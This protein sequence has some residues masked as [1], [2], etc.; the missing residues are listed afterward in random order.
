MPKIEKRL[1]RKIQF[2]RARDANRN[3]VTIDFGCVFDQF[4]KYQN[5]VEPKLQNYGNDSVML[6]RRVTGNDDDTVRFVLKKIRMDGIPG[7]ANLSGDERSIDVDEDEGVTESTHVV[8]FPD[9]IIGV[10][11]NWYGPHP[12]TIVPYLTHDAWDSEIRDCLKGA[13]TLGVL[14]QEG[15][16]GRVVARDLIKSITVVV[17]SSDIP[18]FDARNSDLGEVLRALRDIGKPHIVEFALKAER[19]GYLKDAAARLR[20]WFGKG[21]DLPFRKAIVVA[22]LPNDEGTHTVDL[23]KDRVTVEKSVKPKSGRSKEISQTD[24]FR[25]IDEG[26]NEMKEILITARDAHGDFV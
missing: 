8:A 1:K 25:A 22:K 9:G 12:T 3:P 15:S 10:E 26:Y 19:G 5:A 17:N 11:S 16:V 18:S 23:L 21:K 20:G 7:I 2:Y 6:M 24:I 14:L 13:A 4:G